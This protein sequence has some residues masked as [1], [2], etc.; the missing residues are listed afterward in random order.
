MLASTTRRCVGF[1]CNGRC[2]PGC[3]RCL[4][5]LLTNS[6]VFFCPRLGGRLELSGV[7]GGRSSFACNSATSARSAA[8]STACCSFS[9]VLSAVNALTCPINATISASL[10]ALSRNRRSGGSIT[11]PFSQIRRRSGIPFERSESIRRTGV[12]NYFPG[13]RADFGGPSDNPRP[14][15]R[16]GTQLRGYVVFPPA[17]FGLSA[18]AGAMQNSLF[19]EVHGSMLR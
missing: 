8:T 15:R 14:W 2:A 16:P 19:A 18:L 11:P 10:A 12:S 5:R 17:V 13:F 4:R 1:G 3:A 6:V 7:F 9:S